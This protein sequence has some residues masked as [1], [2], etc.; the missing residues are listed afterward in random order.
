MRKLVGCIKKAN[1]EFHMIESGD[2][3]G[4]GLSGGKDSILLLRALCHYQRFSPVD[5]QLK[6]I[7]IDLGF[8]GFD[9][10]PIETLCADLK[11]EWIPVK[12]QIGKVVF[13]ERKEKNPCAMC[14]TMRR[15]RLNR[16]CREQ[17]MNKLAL[18]HHAD[19][20]VETML[21]SM[22][23]ESRIHAFKPVIF[24]DRAGVT[25]IRPL[26]Y[27]MEKDIIEAAARMQIQVCKNPCP[28]SGLTKREAIKGLLKKLE[29]ETPGATSHMH[30][31]ILS[32]IH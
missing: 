24:Q 14:A 26:I 2:T 15:G 19:D 9:T 20:L 10:A 22:V 32:F 1:N 13:D 28:V 12:T 29:Q 30:H 23:Y 4:V 17:G 6:A 3:V 16:T 5:F 11:V 8:S 25:A 31:A 27:A 7:T 21:M 18:G